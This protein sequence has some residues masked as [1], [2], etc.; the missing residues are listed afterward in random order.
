MTLGRVGLPPVVRQGQ[1]VIPMTAKLGEQ[2]VVMFQN[3]DMLKITE[4]VDIVMAGG[5]AVAEFD[6]E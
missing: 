2:R 3:V 5:E 4:R 6:A 1:D